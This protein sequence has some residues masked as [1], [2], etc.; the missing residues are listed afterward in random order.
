LAAG[1]G[2]GPLPEPL[3]G[4]ADA[5]ALD[6][7][8][9]VGAA[10]VAVIDAVVLWLTYIVSLPFAWVVGLGTL[11]LVATWVGLIGVFGPGQPRHAALETVRAA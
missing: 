10:L 5:P 8:R 4:L 2:F 9:T 7:L 6:T 3:A 11:A 1:V